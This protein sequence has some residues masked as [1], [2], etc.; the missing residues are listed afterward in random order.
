MQEM[1]PE[2]TVSEISFAIKRTMENTFAHVRVKGEIFGCKRA[3]SGHY[4]LSLKDENANLSAVCWKGVASGLAVK[5]EDGLEVTATGRITTFAGKSS[6]QLVIEQMEVAGTGALLKLLEERK[7]KFAAEGLFDPAHKKTIPFL[8]RVIGVVTSPTGAVI[9]DIIHRVTDRFPSRIIIWPTLVQGEG[10]A[11]QIAAAVNG[12][13]RLPVDGPVPRPDLLIV[14]RGGGSLEDLW[15]FNEENVI[16]AVYDSEIPLISAVGHETDT[17]L[18]DF[19]SDLRAPTPTGAAEFAVPVKSELEARILTLQSRMV[20]ACSRYFQERRSLLDGL[21]RGIPNLEQ[22]LLE[23]TQKLD[24]RAE[25]LRISFKNYLENRQNQLNLNKIKP[26][27]ITNIFEKKAE[28]L[29]NLNLRL[30]SVSVESVLKRG[31]A[32]VRNG[33][34]QTV[35]DAAEAKKHNN[36]EIIFADGS[37]KVRPI[38]R[39]NELQ[40]DLF[41]NLFADSGSK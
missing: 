30:Q 14:A 10:A 8:P 3:D 31:F 15:C 18:I 41:D 17:M 33:R 38:V 4:Y 35:A 6:Y 25:R 29:Q 5:P 39:K 27:Y 20:S 28:T 13:N 22:I 12:F 11:E 32:W 26:F 7:Q 34:H 24:D 2:F 9:R 1:I 16:R 37:V 40:G 19:V 23:N 21:K 36:L